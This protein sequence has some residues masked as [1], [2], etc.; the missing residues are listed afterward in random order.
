MTTEEKRQAMEYGNEKVSVSRQCELLGLP[1]S[2]LYY[3]RRGAS[4]EDLE[5]MRLLDE[6]FTKTPFYGSRRMTAWLCRQ[7]CRVNRKRVVRLMRDMGLSA[8]YP[9]PRLSKPGKGHKIYP[10]LLRN[11]Q[12]RRADEVWSAD[13]T[14]IRLSGGF[15]YL[16]AVLEWWTRYVLAWELSITLDAGFCV[17]ALQRALEI[18]GPPEI[19]NTDQ[20]AQFTCEAFLSVL[21]GCGAKISMDGRGRA[22]DNVFVERL[23]RSVKYEEVYLNDYRTVIEATEGLRRYFRFYNEERLHQALGYRP[24]AEAYGER[25]RRDAYL[26]ATGA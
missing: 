15:V 23:W 18:A 2:T 12:I 22:L 16:V 5:L 19:F 11:R 3:R 21:K 20:G 7:D 26:V 17:T 6:Q 13:I 9:G 1:R 10:Y 8:I 25:V 14:Y 4:A 24:P